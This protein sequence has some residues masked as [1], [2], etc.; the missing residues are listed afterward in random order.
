MKDFLKAIQKLNFRILIFKVDILKV[1]HCLKEG[2]LK[3]LSTHDRAQITSLL[4]GL[5]CENLPQHLLDLGV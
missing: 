2:V 3:P 5:S 1:P 4:W